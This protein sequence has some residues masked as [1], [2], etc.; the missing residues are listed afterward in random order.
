[1]SK[2]KEKRVVIGLLGAIGSGKSSVAEI[3]KGQGAYIVDA[4]KIAHGFLSK[5]SVQKRIMKRFR[6]KKWSIADLAELSFS[7][8]RNLEKLNS[9][10]HPLILGEIRKK[11]KMAGRKV[12]VLDAPL[13]LEKKLDINCDILL[14][15]DCR[16]KIRFTRLS[17]RKLKGLSRE[18]VLLR[19]K[20]QIDCESKR[21]KA[22]Y[23]IVNNGS[24]SDLKRKTLKILKRIMKSVG[25][26]QEVN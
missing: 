19:E 25:L 24:I 5:R 7:S 3:L 22:D 16:D 12:V 26:N 6:M 17:R 20:Y 2:S 14:Y 18:E 15:I 13:L 1:M 4:D 10:L 21:N 23:V 8:G 11:L 9:V